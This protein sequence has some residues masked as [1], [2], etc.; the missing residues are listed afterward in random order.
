MDTT[1]TQLLQEII[2]LTASLQAATQQNESL[3]S[4]LAKAQEK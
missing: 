3:K 4:E 1:L 2:N